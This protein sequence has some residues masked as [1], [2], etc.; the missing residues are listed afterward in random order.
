MCGE[1]RDGEI[2]KTESELI[3][4]AQAG[5]R[6]AYDQLVRRHQRTVYRWAYNVVRSHD[7]ADEVA[8]EVFVRTYLALERIDPDRP[9][10]SWLCKATVNMALNILRKQRFRE[11]WAQDKAAEK[12]DLRG[13]GDEPDAELRRRRVI[14]R[15]QQ[16]INQLPP[17]YRTA[18]MLRTKD[19]L[20]YGQIAE[21]MGVSL[22]TVMSRLNRAR[23]KLRELMGDHLEDLYR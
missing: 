22:G 2:E 8:Q 6:L 23:K 17:V 12:G 21:V 14:T 18:L 4:Q 10:G 1:R 15:L 16:A 5:D 3:R 13:G 11:Q 9:L 20:S 7:V 19:N